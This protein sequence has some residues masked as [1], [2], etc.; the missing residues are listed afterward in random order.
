MRRKVTFVTDL[1][2]RECGRTYPQS[3]LHACDFCFGP[4]E[5]RYDYA[6]MADSLTHA[7]IAAGP[8]SLWR[9]ADLLARPPPPPPPGRGRPEPPT[10]TST[11]APASPPCA[12]LAALAKPWV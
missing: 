12:K 2:C 11:W 9:Y 6:T 10:P 4:L 1:R 8:A 7:S 5:V 3:A